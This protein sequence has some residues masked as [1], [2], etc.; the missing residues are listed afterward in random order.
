MQAIK[1]IINI[2]KIILI[3]TL[4]IKAYT[5]LI[6]HFLDKIFLIKVLKL[7]INLSYNNIIKLRLE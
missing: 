3:L 5:L 4:N 7:T 1:F 6:K 2:F